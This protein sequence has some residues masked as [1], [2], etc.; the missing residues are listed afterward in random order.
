MQTRQYLNVQMEHVE[1]LVLNVPVCLE[2]PENIP[3]AVVQL[4]ERGCLLEDPGHQET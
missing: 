3:Q 2:V 4:E 1:L